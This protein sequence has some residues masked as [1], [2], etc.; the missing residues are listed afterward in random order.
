MPK[1]GLLSVPRE[2][3]ESQLAFGTLHLIELARLLSARAADD[4]ARLVALGSVAGRFRPVLGVAAYSLAKS[5]LEETVRLLAAELAIRKITVNAVCP[6]FVPAGINQQA[7]ERRQ[8]I[9]AARIP[10]GRLC[11]PEDVV[12]AVAFLLSPGASFVSAQVIGLAGAQL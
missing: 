1:G 3:V 11:Q 4:G 6:S 10:L 7:D 5:A 9:E 12:A 2:T 8:K